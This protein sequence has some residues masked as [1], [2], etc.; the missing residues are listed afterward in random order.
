[1]GYSRPRTYTITGSHTTATSPN[2]TT[3]YYI[4]G[5]ANAMGTG[6]ASH[7]LVIGKSGFI[8][9][10]QLTLYSATTVG[11]NEDWTFSLYDGTTTTS[12]GAVGLATA[13]RTW[14]KENMN[15]PITAGGYIQ[16]ITTTPAWATNPE[17]ITCYWIIH[18]EYE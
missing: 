15:Y 8:R 1:M 10:V 4:G 16:L 3:A 7:R 11:T 17:G 14:L 6:D 5:S 18:V 2:D 9:S 13:S 12:L